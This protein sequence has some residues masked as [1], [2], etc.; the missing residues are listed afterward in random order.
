[1]RTTFHHFFRPTKD[2]MND[3]LSSALICYDANVLLNVYRY[4]DKTQQGLIKVFE[5]FAE[6]TRLPHQFA[7]EYARNRAKT[8]VDQAKFCQATEDG[9]KKLM[10]EF[11]T[12]KD[13]H[14]FLSN[15][16]TAALN[17]ISEELAEKR[18]ALEALI[19]NDQYADLL[20]K[21]FDAKIGIA[22]TEATLE[23]FH[24]D[25]AERF[26]KETPPG[27]MDAKDKKI[28][29]AYGD[30]VGWRQLMDI[31]KQERCNF[32]FVTDDSKADWLLEISGRKIGPRP[33]LLEEFYRE[34][35]QRVWLFSSESFLIATATS[36]HVP[37]NVIKEVG[38]HLVAQASTDAPGDKLSSPTLDPEKAVETGSSMKL[39]SPKTEKAKGEKLSELT[40]TKED[41]VASAVT[42]IGDMQTASI[43]E[44]GSSSNDE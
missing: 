19:S 41:K 2:Q 6:R 44:K 30:Y 33:E 36:T 12:P 32:I 38:E 8:I 43:K 4:S 40:P 20:E 28:P 42:K 25:A 29:D 16:S 3:L 17:R 22:P 39:S 34:T 11:V 13:K 9:L 27:Y 5:T 10:K 18:K 31:A 14:P 23:Q 37:E 24:K 35:G 15:E 7:M 1:M 26:A 21:L